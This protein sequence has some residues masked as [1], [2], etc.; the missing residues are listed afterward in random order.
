MGD[1]DSR[2]QATWL[3]L[4]D[5]RRHVAAMYQQREEA[6]LSGADE[7]VVVQR[8]R[9]Q[10]DALFAHH[11]Q[12]PLSPED[13]RYFTGLSYFPYDPLLRVEA[14]LTPEPA[15]EDLNL[16]ASGPHH[17]RF[18]R[19][20]RLSFSVGTTPLA[21]WVYWIDVYGGSLFL[22]FRDTSCSEESYGGG[23]YLFDT[24]KGSD[25]LQ[26]ESLISPSGEANA[27]YGYAGGRVLLDFNYAYNPSCAYDARWVCP[28]APNENRLPVPIRAGERKFHA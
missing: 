2:P 26:R 19:A 1:E 9:A 15:E 6:L 7:Q 3:D 18:Q 12:S 25:F 11:P 27:S 22:P 14:I 24:V 23:R 8:F 21:L 5:Y 10:K 13:R 20:G 16:E 4:Y 17:M 28:L